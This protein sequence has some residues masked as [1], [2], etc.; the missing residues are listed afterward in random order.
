MGA[1]REAV[2]IRPTVYFREGAHLEAAPRSSSSS[3]AVCCRDGIEWRRP[4]V[5][6]EGIG[7][8][9]TPT[10]PSGFNNSTWASC[11]DRGGSPRAARRGCGPSSNKSAEKEVGIPPSEGRQAL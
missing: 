10:R 8:L 2:G 1:S 7:G 6:A 5:P 3:W 11:L 4:C 9:P